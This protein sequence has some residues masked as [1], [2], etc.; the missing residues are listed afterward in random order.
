[1]RHWLL[2]IFTALR[3]TIARHQGCVV[4]N[5]TQASPQLQD[6]FLDDGHAQDSF[7]CML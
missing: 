6:A 7:E 1:M 4:V 3:L 5:V 2:R